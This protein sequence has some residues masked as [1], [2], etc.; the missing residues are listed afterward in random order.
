MRFENPVFSFLILII[1]IWKVGIIVRSGP[2]PRSHKGEFKNENH[3]GIFILDTP[4]TN[5]VEVLYQYTNGEFI[6]RWRCLIRKIVNNVCEWK[7]VPS[8]NSPQRYKTVLTMRLSRTTF[9]P[10]IICLL[11]IISRNIFI[12]GSEDPLWNI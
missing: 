6:V 4:S 1:Y 9:L 10:N 3:W 12:K 7:E 2:K 5:N 11:K 8:A